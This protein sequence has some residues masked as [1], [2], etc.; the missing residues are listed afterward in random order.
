MRLSYI[1]EQM[2]RHIMLL[3]GTGL[4]MYTHSSGVMTQAE[5][6]G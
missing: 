2:P 5:K 3:T 1:K 4:F 6:K